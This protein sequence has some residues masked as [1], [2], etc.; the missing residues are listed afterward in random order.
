MFDFWSPY[1]FLQYRNNKMKEENF[2][3]MDEDHTK[4]RMVLVSN[5]E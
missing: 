5:P 3:K 2:L 4:L 1:G